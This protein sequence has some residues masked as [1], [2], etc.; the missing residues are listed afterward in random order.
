MNGPL[1]GDNNFRIAKMANYYFLVL[2]VTLLFCGLQMYNT[3]SNFENSKNA[4]E[5][6]FEIQFCNI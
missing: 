4:I 3:L 2:V 1:N 5:N 6:H